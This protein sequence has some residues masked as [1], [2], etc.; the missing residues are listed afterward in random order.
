MNTISKDL[1][2]PDIANASR[3]QSA[4]VGVCIMNVI[5][6]A[7]YLIEYIKGARSL[8]SFAIV[9][10]VCILPSVIS[11]FIYTRRQDA[12]SIRYICAVGFGI[13]YGYVM[14]T[15]TT[16]LSFCY[17]IVIFVILIVY[18][19]LKLSFSLGGFA[20]LVNLI[21]TVYIA[22]TRGLSPADITNAEIIFGCIILSCV[23]T[24]L[25]VS[26]MAKINEANII[27]ADSD[28]AR[29]DELLQ[30]TLKVAASLAEN[31]QNVS[32]S[33]ARLHDSIATTQSDMEKL[34]NDT[35]ETADAIISQQKN[36]EEINHQISSVSSI[37]E[38]LLNGATETSNN[39][40]ASRQVMQELL[41]QVQIS[42]NSSNMVSDSMKDLK[43]YADRM[44]S[45]MALISSVASQTALLALNASIEAARAGEA[46]RG[47]AV[48]ASEISSLA[49]QTNN[50]TGDI[51]QLIENIVG[52][53][54]SVT[55]STGSLL[56]SLSQQ[57]AYIG[58][59]AD[60]FTII[61]NN[62][63]STF[64]HMAELKKT[65]DA[66][67]GANIEVIN[68]I[69]HVSDITREVA[70][71]AATTLSAC[72]ENLESISDITAVMEALKKDAK[73]LETHSN[74]PNGA[75]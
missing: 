16:D 15:T 66:V 3:N 56:E 65:V 28:K 17:V 55:D 25:A 64:S 71:S 41:R 13:L 11:L 73:E 69:N 49:A 45:I 6:L 26:K 38:A 51:N 52:A 74:L 39:L 7:A 34:S 19:D 48:V 36:T 63:Q 32:K 20:L 10:A 75:S 72:R 9:A 35:A 54:S 61:E 47:F 50:A 40:D 4:L 8:P 24:V 62:T 70:A 2:Q 31:I 53:I 57:S 46:G 23:F 27:K 29:S 14:F 43:E 5:L 59:A 42:G 33:S 1:T 22:S 68:S 67:S 44:Q 60:Y 30:L 37:T 18:M 21:R 58:S 12:L